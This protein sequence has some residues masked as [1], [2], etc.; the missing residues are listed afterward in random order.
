MN[1]FAAIGFTSASALLLLPL[2]G[3]ASAQDEAE[4]FAALDHGEV[5]GAGAEDLVGRRLTGAALGLRGAAGPFGYEVYIGAP[6]RKPERFQT[7][8]TVLRF[9][10]N[11]AF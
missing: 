6:V 10:V 9:S 3:W 5:S 2:A 8:S 4:V 11:A 7:A 1:L